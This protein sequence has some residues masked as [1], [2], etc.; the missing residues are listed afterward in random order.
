VSADGLGATATLPAL[1]PGASATVD[2]TVQATGREGRIVVVGAVGS[3][4]PEH[5][6]TDNRARAEVITSMD[7]TF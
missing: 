5:D 6:R 4:R 7:T 2:P 1:A 3:A